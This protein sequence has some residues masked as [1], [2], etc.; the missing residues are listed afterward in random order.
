MTLPTDSIKCTLLVALAIALAA[1]GKQDETTPT[2]FPMGNGEQVLNLADC[3]KLPNPK[4]VDDS[5]VSKATA[6]SQGVAAREACKQAFTEKQD[7]S[8]ADL[9][10][11]REIKEAEE[12]ERQRTKVTEEEWRQS[13]KKGAQAPLK[14]Y[15]Y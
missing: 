6:V 1:C 9:A 10:R 12:A 11:I 2:T 7:K 8:N 15:K 4:P 14:E 5:A 3:D 13:V